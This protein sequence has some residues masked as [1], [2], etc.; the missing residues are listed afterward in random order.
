MTLSL[1]NLWEFTLT[2]E[3]IDIYGQGLGLNLGVQPARTDRLREGAEYLL[4]QRV[5]PEAA[6]LHKQGK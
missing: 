5:D 6:T 1:I 2:T 4:Y 3:S